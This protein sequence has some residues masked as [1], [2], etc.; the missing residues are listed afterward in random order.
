[1]RHIKTDIEKVEPKRLY[2]PR[3]ARLV[4]VRQ[5]TELEKLFIFELE[6]G[7]PLGH[8]PGQFVEVSVYGV[9]EA[10]ISVTNAPSDDARFELCVRRVGNVTTAL[11][12][13]NE[14]DRVG[15]RGPFGRGFPVKELEGKDLLFIGGGI[16]MVPL[17]SFI[18][19]AIANKDR[20]GKLTV[21]YGCKRPAEFL[22]RE[23]LKTWASELD[24]RDTVDATGGEE[25]P[26][27]VPWTRKV[28]VI[29]VLIPEL[30][31]DPQNTYAIVV[32]PPIM[33]RFVIRELKKKNMPD[34]HIIVS[35]ERHMKCGV[36]IC[37]HCQIGPLYT[38]QDGPV[39]Y[40]SE[41]K[42]IKEAL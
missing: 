31:F 22:F 39:F 29:T 37:G 38:C 40:Y 5:W 18:N 14:G 9:G 27:D 34:D 41:I 36:G 28:G 12:N 11:H 20:Y 24:Y 25:W 2:E 26:L 35:L 42:E 21:L 23:E 3:M 16:G 33:Y 7:K 30:Q 15:I 6:D 32:G 1:M 8:Q 17:R 13:L 10:P 4:G 19:Y